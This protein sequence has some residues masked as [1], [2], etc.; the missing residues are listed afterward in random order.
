MGAF[1]KYSLGRDTITPSGL[2]ARLCHTLLVILIVFSH[3]YSNSCN[4]MQSNLIKFRSHVDVTTHSS[5]TDLTHP[6]QTTG[7][8]RI[9]TPPPRETGPADTSPQPRPLYRQ[10]C[11][12]Q[13]I[14]LAVESHTFEPRLL[15]PFLYPLPR[16]VS[17]AVNVNDTDYRREW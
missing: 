17:A 7:I 13:A 11:H 2:Y 12:G 6:L 1:H 10:P 3:M 5:S 15:L 9:D 8:H 4:Q 14:S 16:L